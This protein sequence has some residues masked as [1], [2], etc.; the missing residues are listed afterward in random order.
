MFPV[1]FCVPVIT[2]RPRSNSS[3]YHSGFLW[4]APSFSTF[5]KSFYISVPSNTE[6]HGDL[7]HNCRF[8]L[9]FCPILWHVDRICI[10]N[11][12]YNLSFK[13]C[14]FQI[15]IF[16]GMPTITLYSAWRHQCVPTFSRFSPFFVVNLTVKIGFCSIG[17]I[18][19]LALEDL[20]ALVRL[21]ST[22]LM[23]FQKIIFQVFYLL[24]Y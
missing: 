23:K 3:A 1:Q 9:Y 6:F 22:R 19:L 18:E 8:C 11:L 10:E 4:V 13:L 14:M 21:S 17:P 15:H 5:S 7:L 2:D 24:K 20:S 16:R 12:N